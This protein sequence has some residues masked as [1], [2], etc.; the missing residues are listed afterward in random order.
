MAVYDQSYEPWS[1]TCAGRFSR[2]WALVRPGLAAPFRNFWILVVV[3]LA[4]M[5]VAGWLM[6]LFA[7][8]SSQIPQIFVLGNNI[9][10]EN[11][12]NTF[13]FSTLLAVLSATVGASLVSRDLRHNALLMI[14]ARPVTR[15]DYVAAR[16]L[17]LVLFL[18]VVTLGPGLLLFLGQIGMG[19]E[20]LSFGQRLADLGSITLHSLILV[21]P[22]SAAVLA[23]SSLTRRASV[24][25]ILWAAV[26]FSG[27]GFSEILTNALHQDWC[28]L[29]SWTNL[30]AHLGNCVYQSRPVQPGLL[31]GP[32]APVLRT[33]GWGPLII[34][35]SITVVS[36]GIVHW[37]VRSVEGGE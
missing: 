23:C 8:A 21:V 16:F 24:A 20:K 6:I 25:G 26:F 1:G 18:L 37:R 28:G 36:L 4:F 15:G 13:F 22:M 19:T 9:Y 2:I 31:S 11:F 5:I 17:T 33:G 34:L 32:Q 7:V 30:T 10:R 14:F 12:Y 29:L 3:I 27:A 35:V